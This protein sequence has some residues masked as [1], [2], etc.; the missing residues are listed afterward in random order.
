MTVGERVARRELFERR[1]AI[2]PTVAIGVDHDQPIRARWKPNQRVRPLAPP[3]QDG[4]KIVRRLARPFDERRF[5]RAV[6]VVAFGPPVAGE[7]DQPGARAP[8]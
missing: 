8:S 3:F 4:L 2:W 5:S 6:M 1:D 7:D